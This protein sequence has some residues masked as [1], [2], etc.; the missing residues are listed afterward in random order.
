MKLTPKRILGVLIIL[1][2]TSL[3]F[4][5]KIFNSQSSS[6]LI[7]DSK[8]NEFTLNFQIDKNKTTEFEKFLENLD[9]P[10]QIEKGLTFKLD[11]TASTYLDFLTP[12]N[13]N[14]DIAPDKLSFKGKSIK[15]VFLKSQTIDQILVP[16]D[17]NLAI[18]SLDLSGFITARS[19]FTPE[20]KSIFESTVKNDSGH[21]LLIFGS[22]PSFGLFFKKDEFNIASLKEVPQEASQAAGNKDNQ[23]KF[24]KFYLLAPDTNNQ[25]SDFGVFFD[26]GTYKVYASSIDAAKE[27]IKA[28]NTSANSFPHSREMSTSF[29][30]DFKNYDNQ[31]L[32]DD[33]T[34]FVFYK[35]IGVTGGREKIKNTLTKI[36]EASFTLKGD[37]ISGLISTK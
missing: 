26:L 9:I 5:L 3:I 12:I 25:N 24:K 17:T 23:D 19:N 21:Y 15:S 31:N 7:I 16:Q 2:I 22:K 32:S 1:F 14:L 13:I 27:L 8:Q 37:I 30:L 10:Y 20:A 29:I 33:F 4:F 18:F 6:K 34:N 28:Q 36:K 11:P 35:E